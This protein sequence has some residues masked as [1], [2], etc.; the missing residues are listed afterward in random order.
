M[1][2]GILRIA[3]PSP[4]RRAFDYLAAPGHS[5]RPGARVEVPFGR[6]K[7]IGVLL[8]VEQDSDVPPERLKRIGRV[9]DESPLLPPEILA[10][11][12]WA[13][14]YYHHPIGEVFSQV[15][16]VLLRKGEAARV[17]GLRHWCLTPAGAAADPSSLGRAP[18]QAHL[19]A[20]LQAH[21]EGLGAEALDAKAEKWRPAAARLVERG[22]VSV[23][24]RNALAAGAAAGAAEPVPP[25][26]TLNADQGAAVETIV[27]ALDGYGGFLL[28]GVTGS[29]K[30]EVYLNVIER[31]VANGR[32]AMVLVPEIGLT[33]QLVG[34]FRARF[35]LP[36]ALLH[37]GLTDQERLAAWLAA[38]EGTAPIVIGTRSAVFTPL[39]TPG[40]FIIDE[41]HDLSFKQQEGFR[42]SARDVAV[43][44]AHRAGVPVVL[45]SATPSLEALY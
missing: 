25:R 39:K 33:P 37:S 22:W 2:D 41:E 23:E 21:P 3:V 9:L 32:Q 28:D 13:S 24:E 29:G 35:D 15:L 10:L 5:P 31:V 43:V 1:S 8:G 44:R 20:L 12:Q 42:Y 45:G 17:R 27:G 4:L 40:V 26:V 16:P 19:L 7:A 11:A 6:G 36:I 30:T 18:R 14:D 34:R 38:R